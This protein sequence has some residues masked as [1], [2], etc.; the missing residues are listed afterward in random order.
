MPS[1]KEIMEMD[2]TYGAHNYHPISVVISKAEG[3]WVYDPEGKKYLDCLSAYSSHNTGH[4]H[5]EIIKAL[6]DQADL[7]TLTSRAFHNDKMGPFL[8]QLCDVMKPHVNDPKK[9]GIM[10]L[11]MNTG[12]EAVETGLKVARAWGY[13]KKKIPKDQAKI[14]VCKDNFHGRTITIVGFSTDISHGRY[15]GNFGPYT[16]GFVTITY[17][18]A[19]E[20]ENRILELGPENVAGFLFEPMQGEAGVIHPG[21]G[22]LKKAREICTKYNV[23]MIADEIQTGLGRTGKLFACDH[24]NVQPDMYLL[25][26]A[27]GGGVYPVSAVV[28][29]TEIIGPDVIIPGVHGSTFGGNPLGSAVAMKAL[30][31]IVGEK[32]ADRSAEMGEHFLAG[33]RKIA[34]KKTKIPIIDVRGKGLLIAIELDGKARPYT[35]GMKDKGILAKE[36][37]STTIRFAPPLVIT[38]EQIDWALKIIEEVFVG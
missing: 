10:A 21:K 17:G 16:P 22:F 7:L 11:P 38:K 1:S 8:K 32:L 37:H 24:E 9:T 6:K 19:E 13:I 27:L 3:V 29:T 20:L 25:G 15:F 5:P 34:A 28:T 36:T 30:D 2:T 33:L 12:A 31:L 18:D 26:K 35:E 14:I 4:R 23:L